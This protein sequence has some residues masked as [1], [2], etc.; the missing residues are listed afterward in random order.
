[1]PGYLW[2]ML[3]ALC[4]LAF[5]LGLHYL[6]YRRQAVEH[7]QGLRV[8]ADKGYESLSGRLHASELL[9]RSVQTLFLAS[10]EVDAD[11]FDHL[12]LNLR[13]QELFP[14]LLALAYAR[15]ELRQDGE[16]YITERVRPLQGNEP[17]LGLDVTTQG[18][19]F[20]ALQV[21]RD[22]D[23]PALSAP[24]RLVQSAAPDPREEG[25]IIRLPVYAPGA[26]PPTLA[27]RRARIRG[28]I[29]V[30]FRAA[31]LIRSALPAEVV[32]A[33]SVRISDLNGGHP[34]RL[35]SLPAAV[36]AT[37]AEWPSFVYRL[38]Y[39]GRVWL[40]EMTPFDPRPPPLPWTRSM[41][42]AGALASLL[43]GLLVWSLVGTR[44]RALRLGWR[45]SQRYRESVKRFRALNELLP[46]LVLLAD[47]EGGRITYAN[48]AAR[49]RLGAS[50][51][52]LALPDLFEDAE[53]R[54]SLRDRDTT[55]WN[56]LEAI[57]HNGRDQRFWAS[58][59]VAPV[60]L[61]GRHQLV[62]VATDITQQRALT[63]LLG[64]EASHDN[65]TDLYNRREF[66]R[67][68]E[69]ARA[70][71]AGEG[72]LGVLL[73][74]DLDQFKLINDL[75]GHVAGD[76]LLAQLAALLRRHLL[77]GDVLARLGGDEFGV[78]AA[79]VHDRAEAE[80]LAERL[81]Q[82]ID[83]YTFLWERRSYTISASIG[84]VMI[85]RPDV[86]LKDLFA[87]A[88][89][90]CYLAK[91]L[92]RNRVH[93]YNEQDGETVRRRSEME[94]ANRLR[95]AAAEHRLLLTYQEVRPLT[96]SPG[97]GARIELLLRFR[98]EAGRL[99]VPG[100]FIPAAERYGLMPALDRW[101][102]ETA[103]A[104]FDHL[105]PAGGELAMVAINLSGASVED[106]ALA[107]H[108]IALLE[109]HRVP[110]SRVCFE[111][112]ETV[113]VRHLSQVARFM[114]R[115]REAGCRIALDDFGAGMS[116]F[117]YLK[118]L[119]VDIIKIDGSFIRDLLTD[120]VSRAM[121]RAVVDIGHRLGLQVVAEWVTSEAI[122]Q[123]LIDL[124]VDLAQG[125]AL[126]VPEV[127]PFQRD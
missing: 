86:S 32:H 73:Y 119:P 61:D 93:F 52:E 105:H 34:L 39:G 71:A 60:E 112:T 28:S 21:S 49:A 38:T 1:M 6:Q 2:G 51:G 37:V 57:L 35:F 43:F 99:V 72:Q 109:R 14:S 84:G 5:T 70:A 68:V 92:G 63:D 42:P 7:A 110:P 101:V 97:E 96:A 41:L 75:S 24:F 78:L 74:I 33:L 123:A 29:G 118:N 91:E 67:R 100:A 40:L 95:W 125:Y 108:I 10:N 83:G 18:P 115:L 3:A 116:S 25:I 54:A 69:R 44:H 107:G 13:P 8:L 77:P 36:G 122:M 27:E 19:N 47:A 11:E 103:L 16:H 45:M 59:S 64:Y 81:R 17:L 102:I 88:D 90:A 4:A 53:Q 113:A 48:Q 66:E 9:V 124:G 94:W 127:V 80:Q 56:N 31:D 30:S 65:L 62:V 23:Q 111:I 50:L 87:Q 15:R 114:Q 82:R 76:Q 106:D 120:E 89:T 98:D 26:P 85:E 22:T 12:Y 20:D 46:A 126:H 55:A 104:H 58:V 117:G 121:V 79:P